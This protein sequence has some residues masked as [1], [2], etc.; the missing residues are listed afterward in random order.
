MDS[1]TNSNYTC[2]GKNYYT[3]QS[4]RAEFAPVDLSATRKSDYPVQPGWEMAY[5]HFVNV[6]N[7]QMPNTLALLVPTASFKGNRP[8]LA[9]HPL[10]WET[11]TKVGTGNI[12]FPP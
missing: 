8:L 7:K 11:L 12:G 10:A 5:N 3:T 9:S 2:N 6:E 4:T 1:G